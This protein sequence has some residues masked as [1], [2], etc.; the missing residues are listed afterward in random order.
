MADIPAVLWRDRKRVLGMPISFT[1][2]EIYGDRLIAR[3]G[4]L[5]TETNETLLYRILDIKLICTLGQKIFGV[6]TLTLYCTDQS[7]PTLRM[8]N[9]KNPERVRRFLSDL[10]ENE[11]RAKGATSREVY[12]M[13]RH[14]GHEG[15][16]HIV[17]AD[18]DGVPDDTGPC[19]M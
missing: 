12:G 10:V 2:Y 1:R 4:L 14:G 19:G 18:G 15:R 5:R 9:I 11:R 13:F 7:H 6:G 8:H 17:D 16:P 3:Q